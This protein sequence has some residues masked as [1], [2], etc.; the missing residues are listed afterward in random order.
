M[1]LVTQLAARLMQHPAVAY[2]EH[3]PATETLRICRDYGLTYQFDAFGN[4]LVQAGNARR[5][6]LVALSAHLDH[7]GFRITKRLSSTRCSAEFLG[8]VPD[9]FFR[10]GVRVRLMP[11]RIPAKLGVRV[12]KQKRFEL[13]ADNPLL[14]MPEFAVWDLPEFESRG[15][16]ITGRACD[17]LIGVACALA[18]LIEVKKER[19]NAMALITRAEEVGFQGALALIAEKRV[20]NDALVLSL[21]TSRELPP[22]TMGSGVIIRVGDRSSI[23]DS[24][25]TRYLTEVASGIPRFNFQRALMSGG[26]CEGTPYQEAG[27]QTGAL[28]VALGNYHNCGERRMIAAEYVSAS[29]A[30]G[31]VRLLVE[32]VRQVRDFDQLTGKL[33]SRLQKLAREGERHLKKRRLLLR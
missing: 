10:K 3:G 11:G 13:L 25:A 12:G 6:R 27:Y 7:P 5:Q 16:R 31:M 29:D 18:T 22:V 8:G 23:F 15:G 4:I 30:A 20:P 2:S 26:T 33:R 32:A 19:V 14:Q 21:E 24:Q 1:D 28:C 9:E 17:D